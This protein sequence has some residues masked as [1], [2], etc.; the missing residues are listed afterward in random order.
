MS[1]PEKAASRMKMLESMTLPQVKGLVIA[2]T[3]KVGV[4]TEEKQK[5]YATLE[6]CYSELCEYAPKY[7][8][9]PKNQYSAALAKAREEE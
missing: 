3:I 5:L 4:L 1:E 2:Q 8:L 7:K 6:E 9:R